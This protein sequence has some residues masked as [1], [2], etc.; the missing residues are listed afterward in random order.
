M[1]CAKGHCLCRSITFEYRAPPNWVA[2]CH[3]ESC[4]RATSSPITTWISVPRAAFRFT[5]GEPR[6]FRSSEGVRRG[7]CATCGSQLTYENEH[8]PEEIHLY[9][10]SLA[11]PGS[12]SPTR[13]VFAEEQ[14]PW[15]EI[16][17]ELPRYAKTSRGGVHPLRHGPAKK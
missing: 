17:D 1:H 5:Q 9:A 8:I 11:E 16:E 12:V 6:Y 13:H 4:R 10:A 3:C 14:L 7:F 15:F 2:Y